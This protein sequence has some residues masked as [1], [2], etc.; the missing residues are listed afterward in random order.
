MENIRAILTACIN[1]MNVKLT[2]GSFS[3]TI[4]QANLAFW[5]CA[6]VGVFIKKVFD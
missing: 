4:L 1:F 6:I 3:F 2:F 5:A